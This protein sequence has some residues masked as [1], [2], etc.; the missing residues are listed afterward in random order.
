VE[1]D[2]SGHDR[3][4]EA[5]APGLGRVERQEDLLP[6]GGLHPGPPICDGEDDFPLVSRVSG[7]GDGVCLAP[8]LGSRCLDGVS[9]Q[10]DEGATQQNGGA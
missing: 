1:L 3:E 7:K 10:V 8:A 9:Q 6:F 4:A 2:D 5:G